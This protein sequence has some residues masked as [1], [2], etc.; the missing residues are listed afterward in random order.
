MKHTIT[1][2]KLFTI[3]DKCHNRIEQGEDI[4]ISQITTTKGETL[5]GEVKFGLSP[6]NKLPVSLIV[7]REVLLTSIKSLQIG[8]DE[9]EVVEDSE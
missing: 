9:Y 5:S 6:I 8:D 4:K 3:V 2:A 1:R 7:R